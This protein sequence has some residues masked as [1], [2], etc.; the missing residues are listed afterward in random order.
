VGESKLIT[1]L[2]AGNEKSY[3]QLFEEYYAVLSVFAKKYV[4]D[5]ELAKELV[6]DFFVHLFE[7]RESLSIQTSLKS[8]L[9]Q[10]VKNRCL[11]Y[12]NQNNIRNKHLENIKISSDTTTNLEEIIEE[13]ELEQ[14]IFKIVS[15]LPAQ[16]QNIFQMSRVNGMKNKEISEKL[17]I[18]IRTV[19]KQISKALKSLRVKLKP[20]LNLLIY[21]ILSLNL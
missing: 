1:G 10:S 11:N 18:S 12:I 6:Q 17:N 16:C 2:I 19:E 7:I 5:I 14:Q 13:T 9:Y 20:Y 4:N 8:Y 15:G 21:I 3:N